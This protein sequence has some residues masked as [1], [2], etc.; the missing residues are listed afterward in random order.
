MAF[1]PKILIVDDEDRMCE[2]LRMLLGRKE[3][4]VY[5][6]SN[7]AEALKILENES[8]DCCFTDINMPE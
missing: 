2:S 6:A 5:T 7:G 3:Y 8:V 4:E 1:S